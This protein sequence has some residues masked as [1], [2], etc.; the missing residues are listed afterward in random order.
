VSRQLLA[1]AIKGAEVRPIAKFGYTLEEVEYAFGSEQ[2]VEDLRK[3]G[4]L[5]PAKR[6]GRS[7]LYDAG[8]LAQVWAEYCAGRYD[9]K[10]E[11]LGR[12]AS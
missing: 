8:H 11:E 6:V 5:V 7:L 1:V 2:V 4:A 10:L 9:G 3:I 12:R